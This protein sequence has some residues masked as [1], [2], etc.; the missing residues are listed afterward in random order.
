MAGPRR[1]MSSSSCAA[2]SP[3][4]AA[5]T[6]SSSSSATGAR[7]SPAPARRRSATWARSIGATTSL[8]PFD[9]RMDRYLR[10]TGRAALADLA[11]ANAAMLVADPEV[12]AEPEKYFDRVIEI[13]LTTLEPHVVGPHTPD[14]ARPLSEIAAAVESEGYPDGSPPRSSAP[15]RT[16]RT[17]TSRAPPPSRSRRSTTAR[18]CRRTS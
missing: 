9:E 8:F 17:R 3:L 5:R 18:R 14:L 12:E 2:S 13:D 4:R 7:R 10:G 15:A 16:R 6:R 11:K 1:R